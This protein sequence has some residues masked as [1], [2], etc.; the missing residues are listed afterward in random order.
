MTTDEQLAA[1]RVAQFFTDVRTQIQAV[2]TAMTTNAFTISGQ[3]FLTVDQVPVAATFL[4]ATD[5]KVSVGQD[6]N[7][8]A[9]YE[10]TAP[11]AWVS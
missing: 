2:H 7:G 6:D 4:N 3:I 9:L 5:V 11:V 8:N 1:I 10:W